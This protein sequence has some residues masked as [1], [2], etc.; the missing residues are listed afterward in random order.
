MGMLGKILGAGIG[1]G[2]MGPLGA[3]LGYFIASSFDG[4][5][6]A[7]SG[8][9][10][11]TVYDRQAADPNP[12][13]SFAGALVVLFAAVARADRKIHAKE[14]EFIQKYLTDKFG[15]QNSA[16]MMALFNHSVKQS[17]DHVAVAYQVKQ[18]VDY[19]SRLQLL[20]MLYGLAQADGQIDAEEN[21]VIGDIA[22]ALGIKARD[23]E[24]IRAIYSQQDTSPYKVLGLKHEA[25]NDEIKSAYRSLV[26]KYHPDKV[27]HLGEE[28]VNIA[29]EKF[30]AV[31][32]AYDLIKKERGF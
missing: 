18:H 8:T 9:R 3:I 17:F 12:A 2:L 10:T 1:W 29:Q 19:Y 21:R 32:K 24:S 15:R 4:R 23:H 6:S 7:F 5:S 31:K 30:K 28:F 14:V 22:E 16:D 27:S 26:R 11:R 25:T 20:Q 13:G